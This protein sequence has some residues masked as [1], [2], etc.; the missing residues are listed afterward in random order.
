MDHSPDGG[1]LGGLGGALLVG[2]GPFT[3]PSANTAAAH[4]ARATGPR[5]APLALPSGFGS[6]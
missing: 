3:G 4:A 1:L 6:T 2:P 5:F